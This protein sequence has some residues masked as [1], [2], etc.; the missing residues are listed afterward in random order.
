MSNKSANIALSITLLLVAVLS[1]APEVVTQQKQIIDYSYED[2]LTQYLPKIDLDT[3]MNAASTK[4][5]QN[6]ALKVSFDASE[7]LQMV[8]D[9]MMVKND[10]IRMMDGYTILLY[11][12]N[13]EIEAGR[14]RNRLFDLAPEWDAKFSYKLPT[15][16]V[17]IGQFF[18]QI[19]A[20]PLYREIRNYYPTASI[21]PDKFPIEND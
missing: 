13:N 8:I 4:I 11:S 5:I 21:V 7:K 3:Q 16:F 9:S 6:E 2:D 17:K 14:V 10:S 1:C 18:Q 12:G 20:Q 19:E 15:Y